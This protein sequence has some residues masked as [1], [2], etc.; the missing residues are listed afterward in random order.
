[1]LLIH[2]FQAILLYKNAYCKYCRRYKKMAIKEL[3]NLIHE[4]YYRQIQFPKENSCYS[5]NLLLVTKLIE[6]EPDATNSN[7]NYQSYLK[8]KPK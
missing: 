8:R 2:S 6:K 5:I 4:N 1:M 7:Q 3:K